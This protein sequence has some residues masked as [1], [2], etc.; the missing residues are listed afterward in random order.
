MKPLS[1]LQIRQMWLDFF[2]SKGHIIIPSASLVPYQ[3]PTL[4][5]INSGVAA[6]KHYFDGRE[7]PSHPRLTN[8]Q[9]SI[10]TNDIE[11]VGYTA[12]HH[13]FFEMLGNF[14]IGDYFR[15]EA[16]TWAYEL[17]FSPQWFAFDQDKLYFTYSPLDLET[18]KIWLDLGIKEDHLIPLEGNFWEIGEGPCGPDTEIFY[19]RGVGYDPQGLGIELLQKEL[20]N[21][22]Y[23]EIWNIV[24]SQYQSDPKVKRSQYK[25][26]PNKNIDTGSG[27]ERLA[28]I[29]QGTETNFETDLFFP[30]IRQTE[31]LASIAYTESGYRPYRVIADHIRTLTFALA[32]GALFSNEGRG[33]VLRRILR[34]ALRY[35][36]KI[37]IYQPFLY[38]L[39]PTVISIMQGFYPY[40]T[41]HQSRIEKMVLAEENRF[42]HTLV[43]GESLLKTMLETSQTISGPQAFKLYDTY[44][45][46]IELTTEIAS[47]HQIEVDLS[48]FE[49]EMEKQKELARQARTQTGSMHKQSSA[50][51]SFTQPS[52]FVE[53]VTTLKA[54]VIGLFKDGEH[55]NVLDD[56]GDVMFSTT[57]F[58]AESGGQIDDTGY[59]ESST[60]RAEVHHVV[61]APHKQH[62]HSVTLSYGQLKLGDEVTLTLDQ[63]RRD[64]I[65]KNH[66]SVH[67][68][69]AS[70]KKHL[71]SH[72]LQQGSYV[73]D[74]YARFDFSHDTRISESDLLLIEK[75]VITMIE[76]A[77]PTTIEKLPIEEARKSG[78][79]APFD[80][81]YGDIVRVVT[82]NNRSKE[83]C[84]GT[85]V[86]NTKDIGMFAI[87]SEESIASGTRRI[88]VA[89][90]LK[91][92]ERFKQKEQALTQIRHLVKATSSSEVY[93]RIKAML[94][95]QT[96][97]RQALEEANVHQANM[98]A[99]TLKNSFVHTPIIH[100]FSY[101]PSM[102]RSLMLHVIDQLKLSH[103]ESVMILIGKDK[104]QY[105]LVAYVGPTLIKQGY[106]AGQLIK[107]VSTTLLGSGG[108]KPDLAFGA[109]K[110]LD[111]LQHVFEGLMK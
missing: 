31:T 46:P 43:H 94:Q 7:I 74:E 92:Y 101:Q 3:D 87:M 107:T 18:K 108:G 65:T 71:G 57:L 32:D 109:G 73:G 42:I 9:K 89:T 34:R 55:V 88:T 4:L 50:L 100:L 99:S 106:H 30:I 93:D 25:E 44:G 104:D 35:G 16:I 20:S 70:L 90:G 79:T 36:R 45:F 23:I 60:M 33:Y 95:E 49:H 6:I 77:T 82:L 53:T 97:L 76:D 39:V 51:L 47:E 78:A 105:P 61:K 86:T 13:T 98:L 24:F 75:D 59:V 96:T 85:H 80:E 91:A 72:I 41:H 5:W 8:A 40:L 22:R 21:D 63:P 62:L 102:T 56:E 29:M 38:T 1:G 58:Y 26:L 2:A 67:L 37:G 111:R 54:S 10:R 81:K 66:S 15:K 83:F 14:S 17:L 19:D 52:P 103:P 69:Q 27:L 68:L 110:S 84:G 28:C 48:G 12:R 11:Q 64:K